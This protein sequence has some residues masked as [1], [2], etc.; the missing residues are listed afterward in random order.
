[1]TKPIEVEIDDL[2]NIHTLDATAHLPV[3]A[4]TLRCEQPDHSCFLLSEVALSDW[5]RPE[6]EEAW[7]YLQQVR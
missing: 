4:T 3:G 7:A 2:G 1:M 6:E 5:L